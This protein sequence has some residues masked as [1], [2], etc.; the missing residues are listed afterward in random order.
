[1]ISGATGTWPCG[2]DEPSVTDAADSGLH[3][4]IAIDGGP[5]K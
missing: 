1:M 2:D 4:A 5:V 3:A